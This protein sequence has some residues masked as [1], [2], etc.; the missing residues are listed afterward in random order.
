MVFAGLQIFSACFL[1]F[2]FFIF[3]LPFCSWS[4]SWSRFPALGEKGRRRRTGEQSRHLKVQRVCRRT[5]E[6][7]AEWK[8]VRE[9]EVSSSSRGRGR[10]QNKRKAQN[11]MLCKERWTRWI[12]RW[13]G[14]RVVRRPERETEMR[15]WEWVKRCEQDEE[16]RRGEVNDVCERIEVC[17]CVYCALSENN[18]DIQKGQSS[19]IYIYIIYIIWCWH[20]ET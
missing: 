2:F 12:R 6:R 1:L 11:T 18:K 4:W 7:A 17:M 3:F 16:F 14:V 10:E 20:I 13:S 8:S 15:E 5:S 9:G 19:Y